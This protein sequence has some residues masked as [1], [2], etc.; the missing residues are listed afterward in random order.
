MKSITATGSSRWKIRSIH[1]ISIWLHG[2]T[3]HLVGVV[4]RYEEEH[5]FIPF[6]Y[7]IIKQRRTPGRKP[8]EGMRLDQHPL[9]FPITLRHVFRAL[10]TDGLAA[11]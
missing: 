1:R 5:N 9:V 6:E 10:K 3:A 4:D 11:A 8:G 7:G 2:E